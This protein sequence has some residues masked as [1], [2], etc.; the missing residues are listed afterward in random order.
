MSVSNGSMDH[1][2]ERNRGRG[3]RG[4]TSMLLEMLPAGSVVLPQ[5]SRTSAF[6]LYV[7]MSTHQGVPHVRPERR[8]PRK[9][10]EPLEGERRERRLEDGHRRG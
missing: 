10:V 5:L 2:S 3:A 7:R 4:E 1:A 6:Q 8:A 9:Q